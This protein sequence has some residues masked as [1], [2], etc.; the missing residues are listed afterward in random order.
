MEGV[1]P[2][3]VGGDTVRTAGERTSSTPVEPPPERPYHPRVIWA[4]TLLMVIAFVLGA[5]AVLRLSWILGLVAVA[6]LLV[7]AGIA[8][9]GRIFRDTHG[10]S[11]TRRELEE[12]KD[13]SGHET[14]GRDPSDTGRVGGLRGSSPR[15]PPNPRGVDWLL[16]CG[17]VQIVLAGWLL[18]GHAVLSYPVLTRTGNEGRWRDITVGVV[19]LLVGLWTARST[20][21]TLLAAAIGLLCG[22]W[23]IAWTAT[24]SVPS[25]DMRA[26]EWT[27]GILITLV[28]LVY[29]AVALRVRRSRDASSTA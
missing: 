27:L 9:R 24:S 26:N 22:P 3:S 16:F 19:L 5:I 4:G 29:A 2:Q 7:G 28:S 15:P 21:P 10:V 23:L 13:P 25:D 6:V 12:L 18:I 1:G 17:V 14:V 11:P 8:W 20:R